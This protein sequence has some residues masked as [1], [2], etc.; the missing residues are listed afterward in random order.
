MTARPNPPTSLHVLEDRFFKVRVNRNLH[1]L[2][3]VRTEAT[4][5]D[6]QEARQVYKWLVLA[7]TPYLRFRMLIDL[8]LAKG[9][10][11]ND[12]ETVIREVW[13]PTVLKFEKLAALVA[14]AAGRLQVNRMFREHGSPGKGFLSLEE[15]MTFLNVPTDALS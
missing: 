8:R 4:F 5:V 9:N 11:G 12:I 6:V 1:L 13:F 15:A 3:I 10:T 14:T 2:H 7:V